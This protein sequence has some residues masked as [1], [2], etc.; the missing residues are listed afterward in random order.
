M[1]LQVA[2]PV[3]GLGFGLVVNLNLKFKLNSESGLARKLA[4][5]PGRPGTLALTALE[6]REL[7][8]QIPDSERA[9]L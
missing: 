8:R 5:G 3:L 1:G 6:K 2:R 9:L 7:A 4:A